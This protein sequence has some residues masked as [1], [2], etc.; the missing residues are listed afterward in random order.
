ML[1]HD[2]LYLLRNMFTA[3]RLMYLL[4]T[5]PC[6]DSPVLPLFDATIRES[7]SVTLNVDLT[8]RQWSQASLPVRWGAGLGVRSVSVVSLAPSAY[9]L[10]PQ[11][12]QSSRLL[13]YPL[14]SVTSTRTLEL[15]SPCQ[16]GLDKTVS[17]SPAPSAPSSRAQRTWDDVMHGLHASYCILVPFVAKSGDIPQL[18]Y[19]CAAPVCAL[20][21]TRGRM[22]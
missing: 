12:L 22:A 1:S 2:S 20:E 3:P 7:L 11:T 10:Q 14:A 9:W 4:R 8:G 13:S 16:P 17:S 6:T 21:I 19:G 15:S 18:L 5:A